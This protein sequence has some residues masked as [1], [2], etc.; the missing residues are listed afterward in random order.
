LQNGRTPLGLSQGLFETNSL[1]FNPGWDHERKTPAN[2]QDVRDLQRVLKTQ[3]Q[4]STAAASA[5]SSSVVVQSLSEVPEIP[6]ER[7]PMAHSDGGAQHIAP[8]KADASTARSAKNAKGLDHFLW[9]SDRDPSVANAHM[10][11]GI[12]IASPIEGY[13]CGTITHATRPTGYPP[14]LS[15]AN[16]WTI[17]CNDRGSEFESVWF[18]VYGYWIAVV[19]RESSGG[20]TGSSTSGVDL[21]LKRKVLLSPKRHGQSL[22][23]QTRNL[24][25]K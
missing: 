25:R 7:A 20:T 9:A 16:P 10:V 23:Q 5:K 15:D 1:T 6:P 14:R 4:S 11:P 8:A 13:G 17:V 21:E 3:S 24:E 19:E 22:C 18:P 12:S 2:F